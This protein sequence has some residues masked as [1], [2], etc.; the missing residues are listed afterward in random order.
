MAYNKA[1]APCGLGLKGSGLS[2][3]YGYRAS[4]PDKRFFISGISDTYPPMIFFKLP[5]G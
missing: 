5:S 1:V 3:A 2:G 4:V